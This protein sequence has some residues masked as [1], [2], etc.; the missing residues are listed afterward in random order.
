MRKPKSFLYSTRASGPRLQ[1]AVQCYPGESCDCHLL[2]KLLTERLP[3]LR[4]AVLPLARV[5]HLGEQAAPAPQRKRIL[6]RPAQYLP[7][8]PWP[9]PLSFP[10]EGTTLSPSSVQVCR[11]L[12]PMRTLRFPG[13]CDWLSGRL[14]VSAQPIIDN[15]YQP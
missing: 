6:T 11:R 8:V 10:F 4:S 1:S 9:V 14:T 15:E 13:H 12:G 2:Y 3:Q 5:C 7:L